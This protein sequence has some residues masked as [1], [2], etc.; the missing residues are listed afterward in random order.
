MAPRSPLEV[1]LCSEDVRRLVK[2]YLPHGGLL[3]T[4]RSIRLA[5]K[6]WTSSVQLRRMHVLM[7]LL[8]DQS[9]IQSL[10]LVL[11]YPRDGKPYSFHVHPAYCNGMS[12]T[13]EDL[14]EYETLMHHYGIKFSWTGDYACPSTGIDVTFELFLN[15]SWLPDASQDYIVPASWMSTHRIKQRRTLGNMNP[16]ARHL[17]GQSPPGS[18]SSSSRRASAAGGSIRLPKDLHGTLVYGMATCTLAREMAEDLCRAPLVELYSA[19]FFDPQYV[20]LLD[21]VF[22]PF[23]SAQYRCGSA[24]D[25]SKKCRAMIEASYSNAG[26]SLNYYEYECMSCGQ[27]VYGVREVGQDVLRVRLGPWFSPAFFV[28]M[29]I[30]DDCIE[31]MSLAG[32][33]VPFGSDLPYFYNHFAPGTLDYSVVEM[34]KLVWEGR[35]PIME[36]LRMPVNRKVDVDLGGCR[37][38]MPATGYILQVIGMCFPQALMR[39]PTIQSSCPFVPRLLPYP[40]PGDQGVACFSVPRLDRPLGTMADVR[41][42]VDEEGLFEAYNLVY[43]T[44][45]HTYPGR[46]YTLHGD[47]S[48]YRAAGVFLSQVN[49][50]PHEARRK[51][52]RGIP[53]AGSTQ[54]YSFQ[55]LDEIIQSSKRQRVEDHLASF[56][57]GGSVASPV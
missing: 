16:V 54:A 29:S 44:Q 47:V 40:F 52:R 6:M 34:L 28:F 43:D 31:S 53:G 51:L 3:H 46:I 22:D 21:M 55:C 10:G 56:S 37:V 57:S 5:L 12:L 18:S 27:D 48:F 2:D 41:V 36:L 42:G 35:D 19:L 25:I 38:Q 39:T 20:S 24:R 33:E 4:M 23:T 7:L 50:F 32:S 30:I 8:M 14:R 17:L 49:A 1:S 45:S 9:G 26:S 13:E 11:G 15:M